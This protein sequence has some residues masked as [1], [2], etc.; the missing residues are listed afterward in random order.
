MKG[1][2]K[3]DSFAAIKD[4][5]RI[6]VSRDNTIVFERH[7]N[8]INA[9]ARF[10]MRKEELKESGYRIQH[11]GNDTTQGKRIAGNSLIQSQKKIKVLGRWIDDE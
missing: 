9:K 8:N 5:K 4:G 11:I 6:I 7:S 3:M 1:R 10:V 2:A